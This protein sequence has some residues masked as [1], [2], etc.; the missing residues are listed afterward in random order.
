MLERAIRRVTEQ[1][2]N[3]NAIV[4]EAMGAGLDVPDPLTVHVKMLRAE[5]IR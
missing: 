3:A 2:P 4:N 5:L 1:A